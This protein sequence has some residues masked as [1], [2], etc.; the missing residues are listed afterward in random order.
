MEVK[1][2]D[3]G[4]VSDG[5][6]KNT[7]I[8]QQAIDMCA[9]SGGKVVISDDVYLTGKLIIEINGSQHYTEEDRQKDEF[10]TEMLE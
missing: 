10:R 2:K 1:I 5:K 8:I 7:V 3:M 9:V 4:A 6:T